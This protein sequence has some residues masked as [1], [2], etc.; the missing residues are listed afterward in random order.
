MC[1]GGGRTE[2]CRKNRD[3]INVKWLARIIMAG[4]HGLPFDNAHG[5]VSRR[6]LLFM[7]EK[8]IQDVDHTL[9]EQVFYFT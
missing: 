7:F 8:L 3:A 4:N 2:I 5:A 1:V 9:F 6:T